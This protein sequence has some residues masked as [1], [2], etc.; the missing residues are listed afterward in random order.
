MEKDVER[1]TERYGDYLLI[2]FGLVVFTGLT[3]VVSGIDLGMF[4][5][6]GVLLIAAIKSSLVL[7]VFMHMKYEG[8]LVRVTFLVVVFAIAIFIS[9]TFLDVLFR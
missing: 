7:Y 5:I 4:S 3:I 6:L 1:T 2:W 8:T 9:L